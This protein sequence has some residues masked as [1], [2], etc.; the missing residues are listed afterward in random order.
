MRDERAQ[1][2]AVPT[3]TEPQRCVADGHRRPHIGGKACCTEVELDVVH[4]EDHRAELLLDQGRQQGIAHAKDPRRPRSETSSHVAVRCTLMPMSGSSPPRPG[5]SDNV[6]ADAE[7]DF[8]AAGGEATSHRASGP[9]KVA[10]PDQPWWRTALDDHWS[11][12]LA[13]FVTFGYASLG[14]RGIQR[15]DWLVGLACLVLATG[16]VASLAGWLKPAHRL[17]RWATWSLLLLVAAP[18]VWLYLRR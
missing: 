17:R 1:S 7:Q 11:V 13:V 4:H 8:G 6:Q 2:V 18:F 5:I 3:I 10:L 15:G 14:V 9:A 16:T 12:V